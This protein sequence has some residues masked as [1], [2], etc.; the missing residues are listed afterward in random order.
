M[1][2]I[3]A[4]GQLIT[5]LRLNLMEEIR[6]VQMY[7]SKT[8]ELIKEDIKLDLDDPN[9]DIRVLVATS[10]AGMGVNFKGVYH[11][12][13]YGPPKDMDAFVQ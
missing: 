11:V 2:P 10:A 5:T 9:G 6:H 12:I 7:H 8:P 13:N 3:N 4:C 1:C